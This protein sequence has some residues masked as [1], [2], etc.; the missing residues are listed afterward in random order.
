MGIATILGTHEALTPG[1]AGIKEKGDMRKE[2]GE[3]RK[4]MRS[5]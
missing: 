2:K 4:T 5:D 1:L 3:M